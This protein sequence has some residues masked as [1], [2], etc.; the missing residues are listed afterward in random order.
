MK[1]PFSGSSVTGSKNDFFG[2]HTT[3]DFTT[4]SCRMS[5][6]DNKS[7]R[8]ATS[9]NGFNQCEYSKKTTEWIIW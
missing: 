6:T 1:Q 7:L 8:A 9:D 5:A 2:R 3:L 4:R